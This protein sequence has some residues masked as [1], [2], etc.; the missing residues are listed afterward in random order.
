[1][2]LLEKY[3]SRQFL[4][5]LMSFYRRQLEP[6]LALIQSMESNFFYCLDERYILACLKSRLRFCYDV[7]KG[8]RS[9]IELNRHQC[10]AKIEAW[11]G[12]IVGV[13]GRGWLSCG[14]WPGILM[15]LFIGSVGEL[16]GLS[17]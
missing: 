12:G 13:M 1:M 16:V 5:E 2:V 11:S 3:S 9:K 10:T 7:R 8:R 4:L 17:Y 6:T 14:I 15:S